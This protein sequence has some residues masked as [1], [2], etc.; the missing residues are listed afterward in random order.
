MYEGI[1]Q[2]II[3]GHYSIKDNWYHLHINT[4]FVK[5]KISPVWWIA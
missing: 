5:K 3:Q 1:S 2:G 4:L